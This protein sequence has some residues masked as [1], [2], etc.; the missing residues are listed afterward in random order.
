[1]DDIKETTLEGKSQERANF[2]MACYAAHLASGSS[3]HCKS[4]KATT[5]KKYLLNI[6]K[7]LEH[8]LP[9]DPRKQETAPDTLATCVQAVINEVS[10]WEGIPRRNEPYTIEMQEDIESRSTDS[11]HSSLQ[12][13]MTDWGIVCLHMG[14]RN[15]EWA[16]PK[17]KSNIINPK[18]NKFNEPAAFTLRDLKFQDAKG[19]KIETTSLNDPT[20]AE[21]AEYVFVTFRTQKN[22]EDGETRNFA[23][24]N[25]TKRCFVRCMISIVKRH[26]ILT[27]GN[28]EVPLAI[29]QNSYG[30]VK[31]I[32]ATEIDDTLRQSAARV[33]NINTSTN[34]G[35]QAI[36]KWS[37]H[38]YRVGACCLLYSNGFAI[39][40]IK[41]ILRWKSDTWMTYLRNLKIVAKQQA[42][43][44]GSTMPMAI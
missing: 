7:F 13:A 38:S 24:S 1:M 36:S 25:N 20:I 28:S 10:R 30:R 34:E 12:S 29:Y 23:K 2:Q 42:Q 39:T 31:N 9:F 15:T 40:Q 18:L 44:I 8:Y 11:D 14:P 21:S 33:Y 17:G 3:L 6:A 16:Q 41:W 37:S 22:G 27:E 4:I 26:M 5:I 32:T 19:R 43:T 35:Q